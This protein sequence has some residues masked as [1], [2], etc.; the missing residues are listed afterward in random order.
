MYSTLYT[1]VFSIFF[2]K[3]S[4]RFIFQMNRKLVKN[5]NHNSYTDKNYKILINITF[6]SSFPLRISYTRITNTF[7]IINISY[8]K[9]YYYILILC[10]RK[11]RQYHPLFES[12]NDKDV[13]RGGQRGAAA[14]PWRTNFSGKKD[15]F[16]KKI[17]IFG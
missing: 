7:C 6:T 11:I 17:G 1:R 4:T 3:E 10:H 2:Y 13:P 5:L 16:L 8:S 12:L 9:I 14:P 15:R